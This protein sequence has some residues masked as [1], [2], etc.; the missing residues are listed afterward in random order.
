MD[1][2]FQERHDPGAFATDVIQ[3]SKIVLVRDLEMLGDQAAHLSLWQ[4][5]S[6]EGT[7]VAIVERFRLQG[8]RGG[9]GNGVWLRQPTGCVAKIQSSIDQ[10]QSA[11]TIGDSQTSSSCAMVAALAWIVGCNA[12][13]S[14]QLDL[15]TQGIHDPQHVFEPQGRLVCFKVDDETHTNPCRQDQLGLC[16]PELLASSTKCVAEVLRWIVW[17]S[18]FARLPDREIKDV[19]RIP[20]RHPIRTIESTESKR[21]RLPRTVADVP[22]LLAQVVPDPSAAAMLAQRAARDE[23]AEMLL[24]RVA[25]GPGQLDGFANRDA[26]VLARELDDL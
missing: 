15:S 18:W 14:A 1:R 11:D 3:Q 7:R 4:Q 24:E 6:K 21:C 23:R 8:Q 12:W 9:Q 13:Q 26:P 5:T 10:R 16:Q 25:A 17:M 22:L 19:S 2:G 20:N